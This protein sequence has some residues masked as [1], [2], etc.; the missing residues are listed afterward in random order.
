MSRVEEEKSHPL[1]TLPTPERKDVSKFPF[2]LVHLPIG[3][4]RVLLSNKRK[5]SLSS[6]IVAQ[7]QFSI[8]G[9]VSEHVKHPCKPEYCRLVNT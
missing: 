8:K 6:A 7:E 9:C 4:N 3:S 2:V 1:F 5:W